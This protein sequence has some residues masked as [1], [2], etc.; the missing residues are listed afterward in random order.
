MPLG[1]YTHIIT[2]NIYAQFILYRIFQWKESR[3]IYFYDQEA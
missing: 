3:D 1:A 2:L